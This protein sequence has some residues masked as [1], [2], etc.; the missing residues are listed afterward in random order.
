MKSILFGFLGG[1]IGAMVYS[2]TEDRIEFLSNQR[3][4]LKIT[5]VDSATQVQ[6]I[7][8]LTANNTL[9]TAIED[10]AIFTRKEV[11]DLQSTPLFASYEAEEIPAIAGM[12]SY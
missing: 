1:V 4:V 6:T 8:Y 5:T 2:R 9:S 10:A 7:E 11:K 12:I 3:F